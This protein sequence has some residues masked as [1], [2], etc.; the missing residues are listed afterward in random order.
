M[1]LVYCRAAYIYSRF[2]MTNYDSSLDAIWDAIIIPRRR[3]SLSARE[4]YSKTF[5]LLLVQHSFNTAAYIFIVQIQYPWVHTGTFITPQHTYSYIHWLVALLQMR[6]SNSAATIIAMWEVYH[7]VCVCFLRI[8]WDVHQ[9]C[10]LK[11]TVGLNACI[12]DHHEP[13]LV[14]R[15]QEYSY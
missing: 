6:L 11:Q 13:S 12:L 15:K 9:P 5:L 2:L 7:P 1:R 8:C 14:P 10:I 3:A 4:Q